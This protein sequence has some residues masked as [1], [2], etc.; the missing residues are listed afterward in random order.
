MR[1][2]NSMIAQNQLLAMQTNLSALN[3]SQEQVSSGLKYQQASDNP[4]AATQVMSVSDQLA[5][6]TQYQQNV[7]SAQS[8]VT[9]EDT[10]LQQISD[11][12]TNAQ[13]LAESV[14]TASGTAPTRATAQ[15][16]V[17]QLFKQAVSIASQRFGDGYLFGGDQSTTVPFTATGTGATLDYTA[18]AASG[19]PAVG[20]G[21]GQ[22]LT[23]VHDGAT[24]FE[25]SGVLDSLKNLAVDLSTGADVS[26]DITAVN[27]AFNNVQTLVADVGARGQR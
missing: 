7:S 19:S 22:I 5:A 16:Q 24:V 27:N 23:P 15:T 8:K 25:A 13:Q 26:N 10:A 3:L 2:T 6:L 9:A 4:L 17:E 11:L 1:I 18:T 14:D 20:I 21:P 12:L